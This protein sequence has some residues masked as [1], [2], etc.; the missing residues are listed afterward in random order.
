[1]SRILIV[2]DNRDIAQ[3]LREHFEAEGYV[4]RVAL[5]GVAGIEAVRGW[6]PDLVILDLM[7]PDLPGESLLGRWRRE[8]FARPVLILSARS[9]EM[10]KVRGFR[11]G[12]DD[13]LT[14]PFGLLEL[15]ARVENLL[16][17][18]GRR[19][20]EEE[21]IRFGAVEVRPD[22]RQVQVRGRDVPLRP[23]ELDLLLELA[24]HPD[25]AIPRRHL[26]D[27][28]WQYVA[29][30]ESRTVDWHVAALRRKLEDDPSRPRF[31]LTVR[32]VGYRLALQAGGDE[33]RTSSAG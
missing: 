28:V 12:A 32:K 26:L 17:R 24:R 19:A 10:D 9:E 18:S 20:G 29:G 8:G 5:C 16:R 4:A 23:K 21:V 7:L 11:I 33:L 1:M 15:L 14:K 6:V 2:E 27:S 13:Y 3:G 31:L 25:R 30:V 22:A